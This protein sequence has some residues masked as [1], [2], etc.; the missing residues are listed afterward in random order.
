[1]SVTVFLILAALSVVAIAYFW[2][3]IREAYLNYFQ[4]WIKAKLGKYLGELC[5]R[6]FTFID[7]VIRFVRR[8]W[9]TIKQNLRRFVLTYTK[10]DSETV[11]I[12]E[13]F[14]IQTEDGQF[15]R[16]TATRTASNSDI[17][18]EIMEKIY[19]SDTKTASVN[20]V[21]EIDRKVDEGEIIIE[22]DIVV[23]DDDGN[24]VKIEEI[25]EETIEN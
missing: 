4:K 15:V 25:E 24:F 20:V 23:L 14:V 5:D 7:R 19:E 8:E 6:L 11:E 12:K 3:E 22:E 9:K 18:F 2:T 10:E 21:D 13:E 16:R 17:P 1:M